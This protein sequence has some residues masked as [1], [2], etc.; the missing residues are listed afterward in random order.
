[1]RHPF[2]AAFRIC[3]FVSVPLFSQS[4]ADSIEAEILHY[5]DA[6]LTIL[7]NSRKLILDGIRDDNIPKVRE[8]LVYLDAKFDKSR[9]VAFWEE[10]SWLLLYWIGDY[11]RLLSNS[12]FFAPIPRAYYADKI[13]PPRDMFIVGLKEATN[14]RRDD[15]MGGVRES[16]LKSFE[17]EFLR[18]LLEYLL[19]D[20]KD[21]YTTQGKVNA[22]ATDYIN[23]HTDSYL[24]PF[25][26]N[27]IRFVVRPSDWG[28]GLDLFSGYGSF[29]GSLGR[30]FRPVIPLGIA[31]EAQ[32][33]KAIADFRIF[34]GFGGKVLREFD[35]E[36]HWKKDLALTVV[37][38]E[39]SLGYA[40]VD[41]PAV[42]CFPFAGL[43]PMFISPPEKDR[44]EPGND[45]ELNSGWTA[46]IGFNCDLKL[47][48]AGN[49]T[50]APN[51]TGYSFV[52]IRTGFSFPGFDKQI[53]GFSGNL[54]F[55]Q[56]GYGGIS[57]KLVRVL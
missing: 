21:S 46:T 6:D 17:K 50:R 11:A 54:F 42:R 47:G 49:L 2:R 38:P 12:K 40:L 29:T 41:N 10:E 43:A 25:V 56:I 23:T 52:R 5:P 3:L 36:G 7:T 16:G 9:V 53:P 34:L 14:S 18:V 55:V 15:L 33:R 1:M 45:V 31:L 8:L 57:R 32:R 27:Y 48:S 20:E 24:I 35:Y 44:E 39:L 28:F 4:K 26:K 51:A 22:L 30:H 13:L 37:Y 19:M